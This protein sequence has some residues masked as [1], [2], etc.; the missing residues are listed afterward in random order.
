[1]LRIT[2]Y[3]REDLMDI[4]NTTRIDSI[5][6]SLDRLGY[7]YQTAG[8]GNNYTLTITETPDPFKMFCINEL[9]VSAQ[10]DFTI[11]R[12][13]F[14]YFFCDEEFQSLPVGEMER[15]LIEEGKPITRKTLSKWIKYLENKD[16]IHFDSSECI[17]YTTL[18]IDGKKYIEEIT[19]EEYSNAWKKYWGVRNNGGDWNTAFNAMCKVNGGTVFKK[20]VIIEN[21]F[22][23]NLISD[24]IDVIEVSM[25]KDVP[26][27]K[28][29]VE[30]IVDDSVFVF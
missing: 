1:M 17:Y 11:L 21:A 24:L 3:T 4:F 2:T 23:T 18:M 26:V 28:S 22:S 10:S 5:K 27:V 16:I 14:Y 30:V 25:S 12:T 15:I 29:K 19:K 6:R 7:K 13:F 8:R 20:P 9:G